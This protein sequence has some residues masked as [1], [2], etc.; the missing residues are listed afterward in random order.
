YRGYELSDIALVPRPKTLPVE[1]W[2]PVVSASQRA[3]DFMAKHSIKGIIGGG[4]AQG[5]AHEKVVHAFREA[6]APAGRETKLGGDLCIGVS[7][8]LA[9]S[10]AQ[11]IK[12][13]TPFFPA[14]IQQFAPPP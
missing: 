13:A 11:G 12:E 3:L 10:R 4:A 7:F 14:N 8:P 2:Q 1:C 5:G 9:D 6:R